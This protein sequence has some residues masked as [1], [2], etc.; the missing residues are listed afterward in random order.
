MEVMVG[1]FHWVRYLMKGVCV[2]VLRFGNTE[3]NA[4][5]I[6]K[7]YRADELG[8]CLRIAAINASP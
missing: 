3:I 7:T 1:S 5:A 4:N 6:G 8:I 2:D